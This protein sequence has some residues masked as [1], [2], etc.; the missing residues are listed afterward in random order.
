MPLLMNRRPHRWEVSSAVQRQRLLRFLIHNL[1]FAKLPN[2]T[3][4]FQQLL[5]QGQRQWP[6]SQ[7]LHDV[8]LRLVPFVKSQIFRRCGWLP[9]THQ[10]VGCHDIVTER[11]DGIDHV[12]LSLDAIATKVNQGELFLFGNAGQ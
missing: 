9:A 5:G 2:L 12:P 10:E 7:Y 1:L 11:V 6:C 3:L 4:S 8:V